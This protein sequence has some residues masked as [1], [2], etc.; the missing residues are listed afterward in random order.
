MSCAI[1]V[2]CYYFQIALR[3]ALFAGF[4]FCLVYLMVLFLFFFCNYLHKIIFPKVVKLYLFT[5]LPV[6]SGETSDKTWN[7][8]SQKIC[9]FKVFRCLYKYGLNLQR[10]P[11]DVSIN[12]RYLYQDAGKI[13]SEKLKMRSY[14]K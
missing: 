1:F 2:R 6:V 7:K 10:V 4:H 14:R 5:A 11:L 9:F 8:D 12:W 3:A 13:Y